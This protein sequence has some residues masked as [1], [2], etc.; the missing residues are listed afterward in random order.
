MIILT[1]GNRVRLARLGQG[2]TL[3]D[4]ADR[5]GCSISYLSKIEND[6]RPVPKELLR[7]LKTEDGDLWYT[8]ILDVLNLSEYEWIT[9]DEIEFCITSLNNALKI[10]E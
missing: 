5:I 10:K 2:W 7:I 1:D 3:E 4:V 6:A 9:S 8:V